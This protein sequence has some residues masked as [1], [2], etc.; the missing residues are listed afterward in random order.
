MSGVP[1]APLQSAQPDGIDAS[2]PTHKQ[3]APAG[4]LSAPD[5]LRMTA[6]LTYGGSLADVPELLFVLTAMV[7][8]ALACVKACVWLTPLGVRPAPEPVPPAP[9]PLAAAEGL[10]ACVY[11]PSPWL[12]AAM[13]CRCVVAPPV[14]PPPTPTAA[15]LRYMLRVSTVPA[16]PSQKPQPEGAED[17]FQ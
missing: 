7:A 5:V 9:P 1:P 6:R 16:V 8:V 11:A 15:P 3:M 13:L 10:A 4:M 2:V 12:W 17:V 14:P